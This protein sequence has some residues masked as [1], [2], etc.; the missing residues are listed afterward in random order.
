MKKLFTFLLTLVIFC[1]T[2]F[3]QSIK[4]E[5]YANPWKMCGNFLTY[6]VPNQSQT[7][8]PKGYKPFYISHYGRHGSR[9]HH[10]AETYQYF[11]DIFKKEDSTN[12]LTDFGKS[13]AE[14]IYK[15]YDDGYLRAGDLTQ[16]GAKQHQG[17]AKRMYNSFPEV[18]KDN[19]KIDVKASTSQRCI[20]SMDAFCRQLQGMNPS[21]EFTTESSKRLMSF[22]CYGNWDTMQVYLNNPTWKEPYDALFKKY[23][24]TKRIINNIFIH[25]E[26]ITDT[27]QFVRKF[28]EIYGSMQGIDDLNFDFTDVFTPDELYANWVVQN[29]WW[30]GAYGLC[31]LTNGSGAKFAKNLLTNIL[32]EADKAIAGNGISAT[33][34]FGH[35]TGLLPLCCLMRLQGCD[36][37]T[38][39][40]EKLIEVWDDFKI[41]PMGGNLQMIFYKS[42]KSN[43]ILVKVLLNEHEVTL[44]IESTIAPY[45]N[46]NDVKAYYEKILAE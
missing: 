36:T 28:Y 3:G 33:L 45:Y 11:Y 17:I 23:I 6:Q 8:A 40:L 41:I 22:I 2:I 29:A 44:P 38:T 46:W 34:R 18:F 12:N 30:Y 42:K 20:I 32:E 43:D 16:T 21:L 7:S 15:M 10:T 37:Q 9:Y 27:T 35:D 5:V 24:Q 26:Q 39:D 31:P 25:P 4:D 14:R 1:T 13:V 19:A